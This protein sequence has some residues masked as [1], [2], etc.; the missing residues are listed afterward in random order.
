MTF[1]CK[2]V[3]KPLPVFAGLTIGDTRIEKVQATAQI[4]VG[5][6]M[7][8]FVFDLQYPVVSFDL[9][10]TLRGELITR[11]SNTNRLTDEMKEMLRNVGRNQK[12]YIENIKA[13]APDG[14]INP[15]GNLAFTVY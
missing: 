4:G 13:K 11:K 2:N 15:I 8:D 7:D 1:R 12:I 5:A 3:P 10:T 9:S 6:K 14:S